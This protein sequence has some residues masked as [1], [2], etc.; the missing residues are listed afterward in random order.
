VRVLTAK[1]LLRPIY[2]KLERLGF[3]GTG[4]RL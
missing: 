2:C 1:W 4:S 3:A